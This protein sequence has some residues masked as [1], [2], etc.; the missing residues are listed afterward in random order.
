[1]HLMKVEQNKKYE[2][3][4]IWASEELGSSHLWNNIWGIKDSGCFRKLIASRLVWWGVRRKAWLLWPCIHPFIF[5]LYHLSGLRGSW[6]QCLFTLGERQRTPWE[7]P[8]MPENSLRTSIHDW[9]HTCGKFRVVE[10][11]KPTQTWRENANTIQKG[12]SRPTS[13]RQ[14][15]Y[16]VSPKW[17]W[18]PF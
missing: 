6:C 2:G 7:H 8:F 4:R 16:L 1:M 10:G 15:C 3:N 17:G 12:F 18:V 14:P 9:I 5:D 11:W 13:R